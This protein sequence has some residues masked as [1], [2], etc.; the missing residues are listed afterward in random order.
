MEREGEAE[1][2]RERRKETYKKRKRERERERGRGVKRDRKSGA[3][4]LKKKKIFFLHLINFTNKN[5]AAID[6]KLFLYTHS[7]RKWL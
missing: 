1:R 4:I 2:K 3:A 6:L 5:L 7:F